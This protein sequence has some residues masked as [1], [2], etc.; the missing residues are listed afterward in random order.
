MSNVSLS[1]GGRQYSIACGEGEEAHISELGRRIDA[2]LSGMQG[3]HSQSEARSLLFAAL[4]LADENF[5]LENRAS[6]PAAAPP[7]D[8]A[9]ELAPI[10]E[11]LA[12]RLESC[13]AAL[14]EAHKAT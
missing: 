7:P 9:E 5:E 12:D 1:I 11:N 4:L 13:A 6:A 10:L 2:K 8:P 3:G 14:E